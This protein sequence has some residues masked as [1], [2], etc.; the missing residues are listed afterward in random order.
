MVITLYTTKGCRLAALVHRTLCRSHHG[1]DGWSSSSL[2][3]KTLIAAQSFSKQLDGSI[4]APLVTQG[5]EK[6]CGSQGAKTKTV[7]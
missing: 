1:A 7:G 3:L 6:A 2:A 5:G 4:R